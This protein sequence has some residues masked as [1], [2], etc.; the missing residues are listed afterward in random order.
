VS[1][2]VAA[3]ATEAEKVTAGH[4]DRRRADRDVLDQMGL[5]CEIRREVGREVDVLARHASCRI[6]CHVQTRD[7]QERAR[8]CR[9]RDPSLERRNE[10]I[11]GDQIDVVEQQVIAPRGLGPEVAR[12][13]RGE[14]I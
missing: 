1:L 13:T 11:V 12:D 6:G 14:W 8:V 4:H 2:V 10:V 3:I 7:H 9:R 5:T